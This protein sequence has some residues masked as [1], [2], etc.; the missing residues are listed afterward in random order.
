MGQSPRR[1]KPSATRR[2]S[3]LAPIREVNESFIKTWSMLLRH[4][5]K[6]GRTSPLRKGRFTIIGESSPKKKTPVKK[7]RFTIIS[8]SSPK[9]P[10]VRKGRFLVY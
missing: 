10:P 7:G 5:S 6:E 3:G 1:Y 8:E 9:S 4:L 2:Q